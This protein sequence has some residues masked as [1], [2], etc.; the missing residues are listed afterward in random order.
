MDANM[1]LLHA[2]LT[3]ARGDELSMGKVRVDTY[4][5]KRVGVDFMMNDHIYEQAGNWLTDVTM[6]GSGGHTVK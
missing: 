6:S 3:K 5:R 1:N 4:A 2:E